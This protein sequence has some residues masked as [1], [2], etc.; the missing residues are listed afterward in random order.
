MLSGDGFSFK[1]QQTIS[2]EV[3]HHAGRTSVREARSIQLRDEFLKN[4]CGL[5]QTDRFP[6]VPLVRFEI[7]VV[8]GDLNQFPRAQSE[9]WEGFRPLTI[10]QEGLHLMGRSTQ[11][12][13]LLEDVSNTPQHGDRAVEVLEE[14]FEIDHHV[15]HCFAQLLF[16]SLLNGPASQ[17]AHGARCL[18]DLPL[19]EGHD[20]GRKEMTWCRC[21]V[22]N[23]PL[24][25]LQCAFNRSVQ[26][27]HGIAKT[28]CVLQALK[29]RAQALEGG[30]VVQ[31]G[32]R[33]G[34]FSES[35]T[36]P[37]RFLDVG[38]RFLVGVGQ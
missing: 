29:H 3:P 18:R 25:D 4:P 37:L 12:F 17:A 27:G 16:Q 8:E 1:G 5:F 26:H 38:E 6:S 14:V 35:S 20:L 11:P 13:N 30:V 7:D 9:T 15:I 23:R 33:E 24:D 32:L 21:H 34:F 22:V 28:A 19:E 36:K 31:Q 10:R 2:L